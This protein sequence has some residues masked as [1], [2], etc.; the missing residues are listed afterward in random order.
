MNPP[1]IDSRWLNTPW[2]TNREQVV[3]VTRTDSRWVWYESELGKGFAAVGYFV[4]FF[5]PAD[6]KECAKL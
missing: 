1:A 3:T 6:V 5:K 2:S 4:E